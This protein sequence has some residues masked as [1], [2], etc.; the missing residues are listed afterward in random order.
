MKNIIVGLLGFG[1]VGTGF[2]AILE[3]NRKIIE[4][5]L[6]CSVIVKKILVRDPGKY[7]DTVIPEELFTADADEILTDP[8]IHII[9]ELI[10]GIQPACDYIK[11]ALENGTVVTANKVIALY[12]KNC[13]NWQIKTVSIRFEGSVGEA[14]QYLIIDKSLAAN[15][16]EEIVIINGTTNTS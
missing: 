13:L 15:E 10:G 11:K 9:V 16:I 7:R 6:G 2:A 5:T 1:N 4:N 8:E 14:F 3:E 12:G